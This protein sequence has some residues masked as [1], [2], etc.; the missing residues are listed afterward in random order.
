MAFMFGR[1]FDSRQLHFGL[2]PTSRGFFI[3]SPKTLAYNNY[4]G[5]Y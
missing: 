2:R 4:I 1:G 5:R 3:A